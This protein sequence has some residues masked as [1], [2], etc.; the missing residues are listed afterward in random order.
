MRAAAAADAAAVAVDEDELVGST[1]TVV[2][3]EPL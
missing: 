3:T 1:V 2:A